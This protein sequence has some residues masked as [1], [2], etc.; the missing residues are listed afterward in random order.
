MALCSSKVQMAVPAIPGVNDD[1]FLGSNA[2][3]LGAFH[4]TAISSWEWL[5]LLMTRLGS[6]HVGYAVVPSHHCDEQ[7][8]AVHGAAAVASLSPDSATLRLRALCRL[9]CFSSRFWCT[10]LHGLV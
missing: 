2:I 9:A 4:R 1:A 6:W 10:A 5:S 7:F 3:A 8:C